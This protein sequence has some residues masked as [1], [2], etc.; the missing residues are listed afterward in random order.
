M[1]QLRIAGI[2]PKITRLRYFF[3]LIAFM[4]PR[5]RRLRACKF[6]IQ[7]SLR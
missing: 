1:R 6:I 5:R 3:I 7:K 2:I 4:L